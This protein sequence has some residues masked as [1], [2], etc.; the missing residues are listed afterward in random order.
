MSLADHA[1][2]FRLGREIISDTLRRDPLS[3]YV[4]A[5]WA[6][7]WV[8]DHLADGW[9]YLHAANS[10]GKSYFLAA[11]FVALAQGRES[12]GLETSGLMHDGR[13]WRARATP[14]PVIPP[15]VAVGIGTP[16]YK[17]GAAGSII[18]KLRERNRELQGQPYED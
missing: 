14:L 6:S 3:T 11:L 12:L 16:T 5:S 8:C 10:A 1:T 15:R 13:P 18:D 9:W 7:E 2:S 4:H 17:L